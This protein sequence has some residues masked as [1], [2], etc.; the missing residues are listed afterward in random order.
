MNQRAALQLGAGSSLANSGQFRGHAIPETQYL[1]H[2][3]G[4]PGS[5][6]GEHSGDTIPISPP[7][8][9]LRAFACPI[10]YSRASP[11]HEDAVRRIFPARRAKP[12]NN[13]P[14]APLL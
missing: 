6:P 2:P 13:F 3:G 14:T 4:I 10:T 7:S 8:P 12:K 1:I 11:H 9:R 5:I